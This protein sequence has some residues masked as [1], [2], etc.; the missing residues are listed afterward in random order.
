[1]DQ[2]LL[3]IHVYAALSIIAVIIGSLLMADTNLSLLFWKKFGKKPGTVT[4]YAAIPDEHRKT[5]GAY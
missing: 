4:Q 2:L 5:V 1:M 3:Y